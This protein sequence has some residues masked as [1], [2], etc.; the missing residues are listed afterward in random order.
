MD[1]VR[2]D[3]PWQTFV[4]LLSWATDPEN[5]TEELPQELK[6]ILLAKL[7]ARFRR[8]LFTEYKTAPTPIERENARQRYLD[9]VG[10]P[11]GWRSSK[12]WQL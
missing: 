10:I 9:E 8:Q 2:L 12:E 3:L 11:P 1:N 7:E 5:E 4:N 6:P